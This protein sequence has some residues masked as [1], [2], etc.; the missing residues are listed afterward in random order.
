MEHFIKLGP[1][2][3]KN[4]PQQLHAV[5]HTEFQ[6]V[7]TA[8][9]DQDAPMNMTLSWTAPNG[10][11]ITKND[12]YD[13]LTGTSTFHISNVTY[14]HSGIYRCIASN[15]RRQGN[16]ISISFTLVTEGE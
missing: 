14:K 8:T 6:I 10:V 1:P 11:D 15:G 4:V 9:N 3:V 16:N 5:L 13:G 12:K 2:M 7:C